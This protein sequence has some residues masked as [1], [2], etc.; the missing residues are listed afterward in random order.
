MLRVACCGWCVCVGA[1][2]LAALSAYV[3]ACARAFVRARHV[4]M[5][6]CM[7][8]CAR[9]CVCARVGAHVCACK[10]SPSSLLLTH[11]AQHTHY[12]SRGV[13]TECQHFSVGA[14]ECRPALKNRLADASCQLL[15]DTQIDE[16]DYRHMASFEAISHIQ[17]GA[18]NT[19]GGGGAC[20]RLNQLQAR[21][22]LPGRAQLFL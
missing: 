16:Q 11:H 20:G 3:C 12:A 21:T 19:T 10:S 18:T 8:A 17:V 2:S 14:L 13:G 22:F 5:R 7:C 1:C 15:L 4:S 9:V 6:A